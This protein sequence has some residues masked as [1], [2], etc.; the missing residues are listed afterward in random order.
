VELGRVVLLLDEPPH[1]ADQHG[2]A[3]GAQ[4]GAQAGDLGRRDRAVR[5][6]VDAVA[7]R[8]HPAAQRLIAEA[9]DRCRVGGE[10]AEPLA[11]LVG[12]RDHIAHQPARHL[13]AHGLAAA[14]VD[15]L[16]GQEPV[17][18]VG[19]L[20][21]E[22]AQRADRRA[23]AGQ[24]RREPG[25]EQRPRVDRMDH[26]D[27]E[28][29]DQRGELPDALGPE[30][31]RQRQDLDRHLALVQTAGELAGLLAERAE[32]RPVALGVEVQRQVDDALGP[33]GE[34]EGVHDVENGL[35]LVVQHGG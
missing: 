2:V 9:G 31:R 28:P 25:V 33:P 22:R 16:L 14:A 35:G 17:L 7:D 23:N 27:P 4:L 20:A 3:P 18:A 30:P 1:A 24:P 5:P 26:L 8:A 10:P 19:G 13:V 32:D 29:A 34:P 12:H 21:G 6:Q 15:Q 11:Q